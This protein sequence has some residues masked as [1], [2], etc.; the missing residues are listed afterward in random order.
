M[1]LFAACGQQGA[2]APTA[3]D[4]CHVHLAPSEDDHLSIQSALLGSA[5]GSV[6]CF[7][8]GVYE[9]VDG[10]SLGVPG[11]TLRALDEG[12]VLDF[13]LQRAFAPG[14]TVQGDDVTVEGLEFRNARGP[15]IRVEGS[16]NVRLNSLR[17]LWTRST[18]E[19]TAG[20][21][22][23]E[24]SNTK[25]TGV[26]V[27]GAG[28]G[29]HSTGSVRLVVEGCSLHHNEV[30]A[31]FEG[32]YDLELTGTELRSNRAGLVLAT[33]PAGGGER[34]KI[35]GNLVEGSR[36]DERDPL[37][38]LGIAVVGPFS[39]EIHDN[40]VRSN[41]AAGLLV[42]GTERGAEPMPFFLSVHDNRFVGNGE[43]PSPERDL[44][45]ME[46][47]TSSWCFERNEGTVQAGGMDLDTGCPLA[48]LPGPSL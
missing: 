11:L 34:A 25:V 39:A 6:V 27:V 45:V 23:R 5:P 3:Q 40:V 4:P 48:P 35:H 33:D 8:S 13:S 17:I 29:I 22:L 36:A 7:E 30:G 38:G 47:E 42:L 16:D 41:D 28:R 20:I 1:A 21:D 18:Q 2:D 10:L 19:G 31:W 9:L 14:L 46:G 44:V 37:A 32:G 26:E 12:A 43:G 15:A 24:A